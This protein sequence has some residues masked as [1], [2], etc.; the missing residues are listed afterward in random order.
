M[1]L[2]S[3]NI[4]SQFV[5]GLAPSQRGAV[6]LLMLVF[7]VLGSSYFLLAEYNQNSGSQNFNGEVSRLL[8]DD[9]IEA[10]LGYAVSYKRLPC[11]D[12][13]A[14]GIAEPPPCNNV[15]NLLPWRTLGVPRTDKWGRPLR[16]R[17]DNT[18]T[19]AIPASANTTGNISVND[20]NGNTLTALDPTDRPVALIFSCG[21]NGMPDGDND[22]N[23]TA[24][25]NALCSNPGNANTVY[26]QA[27]YIAGSF[28][29]IL[30]WLPKD[31]LINTL[32]AANKWP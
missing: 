11:P 1:F 2:H 26:T 21:S 7:L 16:Y 13:N 10:L 31:K 8:N 20:G 19:A 18:F 5:P 15:E 12:T 6:L 27:N 3:K 17:G 32:I 24:N 23:G 4:N 28:D 22:A 29:D 14:D 25:N 30:V 9:I